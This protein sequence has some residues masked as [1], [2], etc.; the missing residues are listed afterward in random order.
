MLLGFLLRDFVE[1]FVSLERG[2]FIWMVAWGMLVVLVS[3]V[4]RWVVGFITV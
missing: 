1:G 3:C 2:V 4:C